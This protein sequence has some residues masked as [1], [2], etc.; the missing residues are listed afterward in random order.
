MDKLDRLVQNLLPVSARKDTKCFIHQLLDDTWFKF[1]NRE[2]LHELDQH[3]GKS[4]STV[5]KILQARAGK[6]ALSTRDDGC[7][8]TSNPDDPHPYHMYTITCRT[9][10]LPGC[11][12][13]HYWHIQRVTFLAAIIELFVSRDGNLET[14]IAQLMTDTASHL[15]HNSMCVD[16]FHI[17]RETIAENSY[18]NSCVFANRC[19][20]SHFPPCR[21]EEVWPHGFTQWVREKARC[22][23]VTVLPKS[24]Q[25]ECSAS[26]T[27]RDKTPFNSF[28]H[29]KA[30]SSLNGKD[31]AKG[32]QMI[33]RD[34]PNAVTLAAMLAPIPQNPTSTVVLAMSSASSFAEGVLA[35]D[36]SL[37]SS[38]ED[39]V[40]PDPTVQL[41]VLLSSG[42]VG[43][44]GP[45]LTQCLL[46]EIFHHQTF[47][48][49]QL[50]V[51]RTFQSYFVNSVTVDSLVDNP[52]QHCLKSAVSTNSRS[53]GRTYIRMQ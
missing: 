21:I 2:A 23:S 8:V 18:R 14:W 7:L 51:L 52:P 27:K 4:G 11:G 6:Y 45:N 3:A 1:Y 25:L 42:I 47:S 16:P 24:Y 39:T 44:M 13:S 12:G 46:K 22:E 28:Q 37:N 40:H 43:T 35:L 38:A 36:S 30:V 31:C 19:D 15:C 17:V 10:T 50:K 49:M 32:G 9:C 29:W 26:C 53:R 48:A 33:I 20:L 5:D 34:N 41:N